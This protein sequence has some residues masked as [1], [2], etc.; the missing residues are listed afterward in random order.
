MGEHYF[1]AR[2]RAFYLNEEIYAK[3]KTLI[4]IFNFN[5][6]K[7]NLHEYKNKRDTQLVWFEFALKFR[8]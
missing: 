4:I 3:Q 8:L 7:P 1:T 2:G 5:K 6:F